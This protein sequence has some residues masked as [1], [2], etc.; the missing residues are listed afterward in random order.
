MHAL[1]AIALRE[2]QNI[3]NAPCPQSG[4][5]YNYYRRQLFDVFFR[6]SFEGREK[7]ASS[8]AR[9]EGGRFV[10]N[11]SLS[12]WPRQRGGPAMDPACKR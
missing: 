11:C 9:G 7:L 8:R 2:L 5:T 10:C 3:I 12:P 1:Y 4:D 6:F